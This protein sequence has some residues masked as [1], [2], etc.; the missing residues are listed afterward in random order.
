M[1]TQ[2]EALPAS[3]RESNAIEAARRVSVDQSQ[4][5][6]QSQPIGMNPEREYWSNPPMRSVSVNVRQ[7]IFSA[8]RV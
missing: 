7:Q 6:E 1:E 8:S 4:T 2:I 5:H 3:S